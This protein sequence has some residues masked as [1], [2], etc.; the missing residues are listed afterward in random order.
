MILNSF[1]K[2]L[3]DKLANF[4]TNKLQKDYYKK[5]GL[6]LPIILVSKTVEKKVEILIAKK[7]FESNNW[8]VYEENSRSFFN[9]G[10]QKNS[11]LIKESITDNNLQNI[12]VRRGPKFALNVMD[13]YTFD[14]RY[15]WPRSIAKI[16][17]NLNFLE[18]NYSLDIAS[19]QDIISHID[20]PQH[21]FDMIKGRKDTT[22]IDNTFD[23]DPTSLYSFLDTFEEVVNIYSRADFDSPEYQNS[24][25]VP[26]KHTIILGE[27][28][29]LGDVSRVEHDKILDRLKTFG[30]KY[31]DYLDAIY[32][33]GGSWLEC[34]DQGFTKKDGS[35]S[36]IRYDGM[37]FK[38]VENVN[39]LDALLDDDS[40]RPHS[41]FW[42]K[43]SSKLTELRFRL[44]K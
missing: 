44:T 4:A 2:T 26:P 37:T 12:E 8:R 17:S 16:V 42:I 40:I 14:E 24:L 34:D 25:V 32:L 9:Y 38:V 11:I 21:T 5:F 19:L 39:D 6:A 29:D 23:T 20:L 31:E 18:T 30:K 7:L 35:L 28:G 10:I 36:Y 27:T 41:W 13:K 43:G 33:V 3:N 22:I 15:L 1:Y